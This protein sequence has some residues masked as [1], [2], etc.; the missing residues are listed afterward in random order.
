MVGD[1]GKE[2][3]PATR[4]DVL[5]GPCQRGNP[6]NRGAGA[7]VVREEAVEASAID[8]QTA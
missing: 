7:V 1:G 4:I 6:G 3:P 8:R 5:I 2:H